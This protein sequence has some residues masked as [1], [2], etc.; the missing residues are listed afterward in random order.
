MSALPVYVINLE[1]AKR[2]LDY[3]STQLLRDGIEFNRIEAVDGRKL[4]SETLRD[5]Q[6]QSR[7][8]FQHY[9]T[10]SAAEIGCSLSWHKAWKLAAGSS[11]DAVIV[12]EDDVELSDEFTQII[13]KLGMELNKN[14]VIDL[15]GKRGFLERER[16]I[17]NGITLIRYSTPPLGNQGAIYGKNAAKRLLNSV[18]EFGSPSDT[19]RQKIWRHR[20]ITWSLERGCLSHQTDA[21]GGSTIQNRKQ[22]S[23]KIKNELM[24]PFY[25][26][27]TVVRNIIFDIVNK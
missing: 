3:I 18:A 17:I 19:L 12:I 13:S 24:R 5:Y 20:V 6:N 16:K 27:C 9:S 2:R 10:L 26:C 7:H 23:T 22:V 1:R 8:S 25:R 15:S 14:I 11:S 21:V 4:D